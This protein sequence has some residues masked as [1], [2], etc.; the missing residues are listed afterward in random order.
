MKS[1]CVIALAL[2]MIG[3]CDPA[4][5]QVEAELVDGALWAHARA[6]E[7]TAVRAQAA[8]ER[9]Q[10]RLDMAEAR[11]KVAR[12]PGADTSGNQLDMAERSVRAAREQ[13]D[14]AEEEVGRAEDELET[15]LKILDTARVEGGWY[16]LR[17]R[18]DSRGKGGCHEEE[19]RP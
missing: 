11:L 17:V 7:D 8:L 19:G 18:N 3:S 4:L 1:L 6:L 14:E 12:E 13:R 2:G 5:A 10:T 16:C 15:F 9:K